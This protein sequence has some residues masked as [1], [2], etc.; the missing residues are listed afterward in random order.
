MNNPKESL[1]FAPSEDPF[2]VAKG[3]FY[4]RWLSMISNLDELE[5]VVSQLSSTSEEE[6]VPVWRKAGQRHETV[7]ESLLSV[8][9]LKVPA[10]SIFLRKHFM[11]LAVFRARYPPPRPP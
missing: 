9:N 10:P 4:R 5:S 3:G 1:R 11:R 2:V 8:G 6:W 7:G